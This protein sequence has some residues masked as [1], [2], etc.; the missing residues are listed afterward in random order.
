MKVSQPQGAGDVLV[1]E[2]FLLAQRTPGNVAQ[3]Q[4]ARCAQCSHGVQGTPEE[5]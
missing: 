1:V 3:L 2:G 4:V 5:E